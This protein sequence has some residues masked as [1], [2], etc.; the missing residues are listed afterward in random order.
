MLENLCGRRPSGRQGSSSSIFRSPCPSIG[1]L[2]VPIAIRVASSVTID[3]G[4]RQSRGR[5][6]CTDAS[7]MPDFVAFPSPRSPGAFC[8]SN[9]PR[10]AGRRP[11]RSGSPPRRRPRAPGGTGRAGPGTGRAPGGAGRGSRGRCRSRAR[12]RSRRRGCRRGR[13]PRPGGAHSAGT[14]AARAAATAWGRWLVSASASSCAAGSSSI[15]RQPRPAPEAARPSEPVGGRAAVGV[16]TQTRPSNRSARACAAPLPLGAGQRV[17]AD[18]H[19]AAAG[20]AARP[21]RRSAASCSR[22]R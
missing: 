8:A 17:A 18:E 16:S 13:R 11:T 4:Q 10:R 15:T 6:S 9:R 22:R 1:D 21:P 20:V 7:R 5:P 14:A 12:R 19:G 3:V 2:R